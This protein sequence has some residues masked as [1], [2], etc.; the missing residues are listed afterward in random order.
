MLMVEGETSI[1]EEP[2]VRS[3]VDEACTE[4]TVVLR[5]TFWRG[6]PAAMIWAVVVDWDGD[7]AA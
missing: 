4:V 3:I 6:D 2:L 5:A 1:G 7:G